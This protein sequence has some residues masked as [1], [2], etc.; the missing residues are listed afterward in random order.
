MKNIAETR[1]VTA[2]FPEIGAGIL[3]G[4]LV[5]LF[6]LSFAYIVFGDAT[7]QGLVGQGIKVALLGALI[8]ALT[9]CL[10]RP[11]LGTM[12]QPQS[13]VAIV[14]GLASAEIV[15]GPVGQEPEVAFASI[16]VLLAVT[17]VLTGAFML[18]I[19]LARLGQIAKSVPY[20]VVGG[21]LAATGFLL[22]LRALE[23][24][25]GVNSGK[26]GELLAA[27]AIRQWSP[28]L[29]LAIAMLAAER[30]LKPASV[31]MAGALCVIAVVHGGIYL[32]G[33]SL[34]EASA[35]GLLMDV[36]PVSGAGGWPLSIATLRQAD[37]S[38]VL[39]Q[40]PLIGTAALLAALGALLN[41]PAI[42]FS[43]GEPMELDEEMRVAG[44]SN[45]CVGLVG[46]LVGYQSA[47]LTQ[48]ATGLRAPPGR[49][50]AVTAAAV[51]VAALAAGPALFN[52][53]PRSLF[54]LLLAYLGLGFLRR[55]LVDERARLP[56]EDYL[57]VW[58]ILVVTLLAGFGLAVV[59]GVVVAS[60]RFTVAYSRLPV[61][62]SSV[63][64]AMKLSSTE[65]SD[66]ATR[67]LVDHGHETLIF[68]AQGYMFFGTA[69]TLY[70]RVDREVERCLK[71]GIPVR[72]L[73][74]DLRRVQGLDVSAIY[75]FD[76][77]ARQ[78]QRRGVGVIFAGLSKGTNAHI[79]LGIEHGETAFFP[80]LDDALIALEEA[81]LLRAMQ[82]AEDHGLAVF[83][84]GFRSLLNRIEAA[85]APVD[86][87]LKAFPAGHRLFQMGEPSDSLVVLESGRLYATVR[88][89]E[90]PAERV[91]TFLP[92]S[93]VGE[94]GLVTGGARTASVVAETD[95]TMRIVT[96]AE[97]QALRS[98]D[99]ALAL[100]LTERIS[101][102]IAR[103]LART[104][105]LLHAVTR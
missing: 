18:L 87:H 80:T 47:T 29:L 6:A 68:E 59:A 103:R 46:G 44:F 8:T 17:A 19:G 66:R 28:P 20:P 33:M 67:W 75:M 81:S 85:G 23:F 70:T 90:A 2:L 96:R 91:A 16:L 74:I 104:T 71:A 72:N 83:E 45:L 84:A 41:L 15:A 49:L 93:V 73:V 13:A 79:A 22:V 39:Q 27:D 92:G 76:R 55:W 86:F 58:L 100:E 95:C 69:N 30:W 97:L 11:F 82:E 60:M 52:L 43:S 25:S 14:V 5:S 42:E 4:C 57:I 102:L 24:G 56:R 38:A 34:A 7:V 54:A 64:G 63:T 101:E 48:L 94:I 35:G 89:G 1:R 26:I 21:F 62:R 3:A 88:D 65:R 61:L 50:V 12:W 32:S 98:F 51:V 77:L 31:L 10:R 37:L 78:A 99:P 40:Y 105:S 9:A 53:F 36:A